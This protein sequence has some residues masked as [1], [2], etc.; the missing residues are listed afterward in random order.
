MRLLQSFLLYFLLILSL[1]F[2]LCLVPFIQVYCLLLLLYN[3]GLLLLLTSNLVEGRAGT[4][5]TLFPP[6]S[7]GISH[8]GANVD[9]AVFA[10]A[11]I[12]LLTD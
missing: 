10:G 6:F 2:V 5:L 8:A 4:G 12:M 9:L 3:I 11:I 7:G 1:F